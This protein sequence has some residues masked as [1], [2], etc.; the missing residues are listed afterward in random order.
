MT[1]EKTINERFPN[2]KATH[3]WLNSQEKTTRR[4]Y[5]TGWKHFLE[6]TKMTGDQILADR[7]QDTEHQWEKK[8]L[9]FRRWLMDT[10]YTKGQGEGTATVAV[11]A[12]RSF[13]SFHYR[14]LEY[15]R[16]D[17][18][19]LSKKTRKTEDYKF[20]RDDLK[21]MAD[22]ADLE[23]QYVTVVGKSFGLR[24]GD[25]LRLKR[26]DL[27][28]YIDRE[29]PISIGEYETEKED[30]SAYP[31]IDSDALPVIK[32]IIRL[33]DQQGRRNPMDRILTYKKTRTLTRILVRVVNRTG[34]NIGSKRARFHC[35]RKFLTDRLS[36]HMSESKW[37]Q[38][39]GKTVDERA[40]VSP[41]ELRKD[42]ARAMKETCWTGTADVNV[43]K[44]IRIEI[45]KEKAKD[46]GIS[47]D[48]IKEAFTRFDLDEQ[49][50]YLEDRLKKNPEC[51]N[52]NCQLIIGESE[53]E[54]YLLKGWCFVAVLPSGKLVIAN[55]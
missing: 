29:P 38:I 44:R 23:E 4:N 14:K 54:T 36:S 43:E 27:E 34:I 18:K 3:E 12:V 33:M 11:T 17:S 53:L 13:F 10:K 20:S 8:V 42:Y 5:Q 2:D 41:D 7:K 16:A 40:Y 22:V 50:A 48:E 28:P 19:K 24:A 30:V 31:F 55:E 21:M 39:V 35:L 49:I 51:Q 32:N 25:F 6:F 26:G 37:K 9:L 52:G 45:L 46:L 15:R 47:E 1:K